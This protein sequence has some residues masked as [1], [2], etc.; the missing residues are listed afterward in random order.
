MSVPFLK[1][2][3]TWTLVSL[4]ALHFMQWYKDEVQSSLCLAWPSISPSVMFLDV[5]VLCG[6]L[7]QWRNFP[8]IISVSMC[9]TLGTQGP[10][11]HSLFCCFFYKI[12]FLCP[13]GF[14]G[15]SEVKKK[16]IC[17]QWGR[18]VFNPWVGKIPREENGNPLQ[19]SCVENSM[20]RG[21]WWA[22]V[23]GV[24]RDAHSLMTTPP[25]PLFAF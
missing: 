13:L 20:D 25:P 15:G 23:H 24:V 2:F 18:L 19:H 6:D 8:R 7:G 11:N 5:P 10:R 12:T 3:F 21:A 17:P 1:C 9:T 16:K 14:P 4:W 22:T